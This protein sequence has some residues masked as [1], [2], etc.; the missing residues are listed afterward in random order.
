[1]SEQG[2]ALLALFLFL[3]K[4]SKSGGGWVSQ[5]FV[6]SVQGMVVHCVVVGSGLFEC[7]EGL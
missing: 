4:R 7:V 3:V 5:V 2:D 6:E 1:M